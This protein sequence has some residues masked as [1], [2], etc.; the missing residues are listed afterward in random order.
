[1]EDNQEYEY[2]LCAK[3]DNGISGKQNEI[4]IKHQSKRKLTINDRKCLSSSC[5]MHTCH[6]RRMINF[7]SLSVHIRI[8][9]DVSSFCCDNHVDFRHWS[10]VNR[11]SLRCISKLDINSLAFCETVSNDSSSKS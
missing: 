5:C 3:N 9:L 8:L 11:S 7:L 1:M 6:F 4:P 10:A 2:M